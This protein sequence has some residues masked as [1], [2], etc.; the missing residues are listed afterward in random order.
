MIEIDRRARRDP[1]PRQ[2]VSEVVI[3]PRDKHPIRCG[4]DMCRCAWAGLTVAD[5][6][7]RGA[8]NDRR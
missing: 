8:N 3:D 5:W 7:T 2:F 6:N 1:A 4:C